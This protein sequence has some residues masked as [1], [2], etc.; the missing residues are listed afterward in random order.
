MQLA[1]G[2]PRSNE[3]SKMHYCL[4]SRNMSGL[5]RPLIS[6]Y[7]HGSFKDTTNYSHHLQN[8]HRYNLL[9]AAKDKAVVAHIHP[10]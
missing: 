5:Y 6:D 7:I 1:L 3:K 2:L 8:P 10:N 4:D 9:S